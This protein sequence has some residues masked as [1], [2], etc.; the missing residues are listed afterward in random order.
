MPQPDP[1]FLPLNSW[2]NYNK[3]QGAP[4]QFISTINSLT[5]TYNFIRVNPNTWRIIQH[6]TSTCLLEWKKYMGE[7]IFSC[8][9]SPFCQRPCLVS[10][11][12]SPAKPGF[13]DTHQSIHPYKRLE[14]DCKSKAKQSKSY[15]MEKKKIWI[16]VFSAEKQHSLQA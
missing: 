6:R 3:L 4:L 11:S 2:I 7:A 5:T 10:A 16:L 13:G 14:W 1:H 8:F 9:P 12:W 15:H